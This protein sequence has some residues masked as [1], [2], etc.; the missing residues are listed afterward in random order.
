MVTITG[1]VLMAA[2]RVVVLNSGASAQTPP[3]DPANEGWQINVYPVLVWVPLGIN[4]NVDL[5]PVNGGGSGDSG[6]IVDGRF[7]GAFLGGASATNGQWRIEGDIIW[8]AVG[9]DRAERPVLTVDADI[10]YGHGTVGYAVAK[11]VFVTG[12]V[13]RLALKYDVKLGDRPNFERKPGIWDPLIGIAYQR[14]GKALEIHANFDGGGFGAGADVDLGAT[15]RVDLKPTRH[16]GITLGY[17]MLYL[18]LTDTVA[19]RDFTVKQTLHGP[20]AGIGLYF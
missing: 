1:K 19:E 9:G 18:R 2:A 15:F 7:D 17:T 6:A 10:F 20:V 3:T 14:I 11:N 5:P 12:G 4:I 16:F 13:R 8:A